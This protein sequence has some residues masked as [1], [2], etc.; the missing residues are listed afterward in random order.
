MIHK[1]LALF[2]HV[3]VVLLCVNRL[4]VASTGLFFLAM[5][6]TTV[7]INMTGKSKN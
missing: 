1:R 7:I 3:F 6:L 5:L 4:L 2:F